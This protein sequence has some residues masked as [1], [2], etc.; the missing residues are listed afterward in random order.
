[1]CVCVCVCVLSAIINLPWFKATP[2]ILFLNKEDLFREKIKRSDLNIFFPAYTG[3]NMLAC[4][5][6]VLPRSSMNGA[7]VGWTTI[8]PR[9][10]SFRICTSPEIR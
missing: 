9:S 5:I 2:I 4:G 7:Q 10:P 1:V 8:K 6:R 3:M